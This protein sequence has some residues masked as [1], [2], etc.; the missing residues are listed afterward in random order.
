MVAD[1]CL[2]HKISIVCVGP[3]TFAS[4]I[5]MKEEWV[6]EEAGNSDEENSGKLI[7]T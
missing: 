3:Y 2:T 1:H 6:G 4:H 5:L 7:E